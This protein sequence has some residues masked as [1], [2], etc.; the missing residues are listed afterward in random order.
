M[1]LST[2]AEKEFDKI[3]HQIILKNYQQS[4]KEGT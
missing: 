3:Q 4:R 2:N 1:I